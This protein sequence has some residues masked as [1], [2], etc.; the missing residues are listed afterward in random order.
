MKWV[1][2][3]LR[4]AED[5]RTQYKAIHSYRHYKPLKAVSSPRYCPDVAL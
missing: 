1:I 3:K 5:R 2:H 4:I